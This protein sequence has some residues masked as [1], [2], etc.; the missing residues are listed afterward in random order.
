[1]ELQGT[2]VPQEVPLFLEDGWIVVSQPAIAVL[3]SFTKAMSVLDVDRYV[4]FFSPSG[5][6][7]PWNGRRSHCIYL[8][9][10]SCTTNARTSSS[11]EPM[12]EA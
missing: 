4:A 12:R 10:R 6:R 3:C 1:M 11:K 2:S 9:L 5:N 8:K 7:I